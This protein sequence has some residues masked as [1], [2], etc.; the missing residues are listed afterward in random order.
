MCSAC[1]GRIETGRRARGAFARSPPATTPSA[2]TAKAFNKKTQA[3]KVK[4]LQ[5]GL[6][7]RMDKCRKAALGMVRHG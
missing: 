6:I 4:K 5:K 7:D 1:R 2:V 3:F